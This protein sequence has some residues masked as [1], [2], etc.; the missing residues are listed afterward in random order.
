M[1][2]CRRTAKAHQQANMGLPAY[3]LGL[4][5]PVPAADVPS[6]VVQSEAVMPLDLVLG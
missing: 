3:I 4:N 5:V 2:G 1:P 6:N